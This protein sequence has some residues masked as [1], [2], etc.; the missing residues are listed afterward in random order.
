MPRVISKPI[1]TALH[2]AG[3]AIAVTLPFRSPIAYARNVKYLLPIKAALESAA[4]QKK[5]SG[6]VKF[7]FGTEHPPEIL[8]VLGNAV[9][10]RRIGT[11]PINDVTTCNAAFLAAL[12]DLENRAKKLS[13]N[14]VVN[15]VSYYKNIQL[16]SETEFECHAGSGAHVFLKGDFAR[17]APE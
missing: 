12:V 14:A 15:V 6:L 11:R 10:H 1:K 4:A 9:V 8:T 2:I 3:F 16:A 17:V 5:P 13:A 7:F